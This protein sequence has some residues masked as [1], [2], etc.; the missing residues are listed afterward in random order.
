V[1]NISCFFIKCSGPPSPCKACLSTGSEND[2]HFDPS[3]DLRRK[4]AVKRTI[5]ELSDYKDLLDSLLATL[6]DAP[7][8]KL[9]E[10][11]EVIQ[12]NASM[13]DIAHAVGCPVTTF[14]DSRALSNASQ[15]SF[16][17]SE[18]GEQGR[19]SQGVENFESNPRRP[20]EVDA[21]SESPEAEHHVEAYNAG[22]D[23]YARVTLES[24]CDIPLYQVPAKPWTEIT[25]DDNLVSHLV[26][27]YFTWNHPCAQYL[28][29][30][31][32][33][34]HMRRRDLGSDFCTPLLVN[35]L[36]SIASVWNSSSPS[37]SPKL[38]RTRHIPTTRMFIQIRGMDFRA[39]RLFLLRLKDYG[40][41]RKDVHPWQIS[42]LS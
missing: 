18:D 7:S 42:R 33:I 10:V 39:G 21:L 29:Q 12:S 34:E 24:L 4:V 31:I 38:T 8:D 2:C 13:R 16:S 23:P 5:Q 40:K 30:G 6:R 9:G 11:I 19:D 37:P 17:A 25:D 27:L 28:D 36:L 20:S 14:A 3:R 1:A 35:S 41:P 22:F 26:S 15:I 32:L